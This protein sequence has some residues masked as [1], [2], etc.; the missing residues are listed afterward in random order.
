MTFGPYKLKKSYIRGQYLFIELADSNGVVRYR[1]KRRVDFDGHSDVHAKAGRLEGCLVTTETSNLAKNPPEEWWIDV[2]AYPSDRE[3]LDRGSLSGIGVIPTHEQE[4]CIE[5]FI[6][7]DDLKISAF[8]GTGKT[9]TL[10][11]IANAAR[12]KNGLYLAF[13]KEMA[14][15]ASTKFPGN[16]EC[17]T[18]HSLAYQ[19]AKAYYG[20]E[21]LNQAPNPNRIAEFL[22]LEPVSFGEHSN[23]SPRQIGKWILDTLNTFCQSDDPV[24][25]RWHVT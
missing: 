23:Y 10:V 9:T 14:Q 13:N 15:E 12:N 17:R 16:V 4:R 22:R 8:A 24:L 21:K 20:R 6:K 11:G 2:N 5:S 25:T 1:P 3:Q 18:T 19:Y 7:F